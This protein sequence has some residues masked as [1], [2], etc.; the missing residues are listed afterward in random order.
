[1]QRRVRITHPFHPLLGE[2][3]DLLVYRHTWGE[4]RVYVELPEGGVMRI[5]ACW[6]DVVAADPFVLVSAGRSLFRLDDLMELRRLLT[7]LEE[8]KLSVS[9]DDVK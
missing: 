3:F 2:E 6:T 7:S 1:V 4:T 5:P 9:H 8:E